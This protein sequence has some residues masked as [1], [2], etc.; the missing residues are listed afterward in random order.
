[1][2]SRQYNPFIA[3]KVAKLLAKASSLAVDLRSQAMFAFRLSG[4][5]TV[6]GRG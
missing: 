1:M 6:V 3:G 5:A 4:Q 2:P